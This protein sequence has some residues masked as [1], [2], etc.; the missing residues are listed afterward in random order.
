M[1]F[2]LK[3]TDNVKSG[4]AG[5]TKAWFIKIRP[6]YKDD[7]G[8]LEHEKIHVKQYWRTLGFHALFYALSK[9]YRLRSEVEA[10]KKQLELSPSNGAKFAQFIATK[11]RLNV[12]QEEAYDLLTKET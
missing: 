9:A 3:Y 5:E 4:F 6:S 10:Y 2:S 7:A 1:L 8:L 11:Y 12:T